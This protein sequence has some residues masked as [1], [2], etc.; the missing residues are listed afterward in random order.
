MIALT[1]QCSIGDYSFLSR[2][3]NKVNMFISGF[4]DLFFATLHAYCGQL[5]KTIKSADFLLNRFCRIYKQ[6]L[7]LAQQNLALTFGQLHQAQYGTAL[8]DL[9]SWFADRL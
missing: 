1:S 3:Y 4:H 2:F 6:H 8:K 9:N 5:Q 7:Q